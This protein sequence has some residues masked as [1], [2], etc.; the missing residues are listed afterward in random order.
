MNKFYIM[1][2][3]HCDSF[4]LPNLFAK[5]GSYIMIALFSVINY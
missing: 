2:Q 5:S 1:G 3:V 4:L